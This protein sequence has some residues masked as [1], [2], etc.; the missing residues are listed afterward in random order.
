MKSGSFA[1][2]AQSASV[3]AFSAGFCCA[4]GAVNAALAE[5]PAERIV[6]ATDY[7]QEV[8][9]RE[10]VRDFVRDIRALGKPGEM[11]LSGNVGKLIKKR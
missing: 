7:P 8:R 5:I 3:G 1:T 9:Q 2:A 11:I 4:I 10:P 6:F